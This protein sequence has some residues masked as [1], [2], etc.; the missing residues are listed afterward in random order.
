[1]AQSAKTATPEIPAASARAS[2]PR[3][4]PFYTFSVVSVVLGALRVKDLLAED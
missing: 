2:A 3:E 1:M 4:A